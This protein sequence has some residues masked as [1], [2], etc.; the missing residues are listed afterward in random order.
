[1]CYFRFPQKPLKLTWSRLN[2][3]WPFDKHTIIIKLWYSSHSNHEAS[4]LSLYPLIVDK[5]NTLR[6]RRTI[7]IRWRAIGPNSSI[8]SLTFRLKRI[9]L[10]RKL[11]RST[12]KTSMP[13][14]GEGE[15]HLTTIANSHRSSFSKHIF[16]PVPKRIICNQFNFEAFNEWMTSGCLYQYFRIDSHWQFYPD[17]SSNSSTGM[18]LFLLTCRSSVSVM[19]LKADVA[20][21]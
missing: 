20:L 15:K 3:C 13:D 17:A 18:A 10:S 12:R 14:D 19:I 2:F 11:W 7:E 9:I 1:M 4:G 16:I 5:I 21:R 8:S 6:H